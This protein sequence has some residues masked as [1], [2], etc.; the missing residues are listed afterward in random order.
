MRIAGILFSFNTPLRQ[1][2]STSYTFIYSNKNGN[3]HPLSAERL[4][5][6]CKFV[7]TSAKSVHLIVHVRVALHVINQRSP[8]PYWRNA[9]L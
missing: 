3:A 5:A 4:P 2:M 8:N 1:Q 7:T 9:G 6:M